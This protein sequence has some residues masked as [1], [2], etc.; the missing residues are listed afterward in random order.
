VSILGEKDSRSIPSLL[1]EVILIGLGVFLA[2]L[3]NNWH[4]EREHRALAQ[5]TLRNF[6]EELRANQVAVGSNQSYHITLFSELQQFLL[7]KEPATDERFNLSV[8]FL[9]IRPVVFEHTAWDLALATQALS[10]LKPDL[11]LAISKVY[12]QQ[13]AFQLLENSFLA[14][15]FTPA[16]FASEDVKGLATAMRVYLADVNS[17][18]PAMLARYR[19]VLPEIDSALGIRAMKKADK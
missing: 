6:A 18:E 5:T 3:A 10:Y 16:T 14:S 2:L 7:S 9:G 19:E 8:H 13:N 1:F 4:E 11:A 15:A 12:T 17:L